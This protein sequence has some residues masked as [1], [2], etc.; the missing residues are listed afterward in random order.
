M[1]ELLVAEEEG[2]GDADGAMLSRI[3]IALTALGAAADRQHG[4]PTKQGG[5]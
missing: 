1:R 5:E 4:P 3:I 2:M